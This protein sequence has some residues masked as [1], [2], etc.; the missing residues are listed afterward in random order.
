MSGQRLIQ[1]LEDNTKLRDGYAMVTTEECHFIQQWIKA[2]THTNKNTPTVTKGLVIWDKPI[3][4]EKPQEAT[5]T[6]LPK[7]NGYKQFFM[8]PL[9]NDMP[10]PL[11]EPRC[12]KATATTE[13]IPTDD[14]NITIRIETYEH[15]NTP[16]E[17]TKRLKQPASMLQATL[18]E[19]NLE[20]HTFGWRI[21]QQQRTTQLTG[22]IRIKPKYV[23]QI[24]QRSGEH[25]IIYTQVGAS[26]DSVQ[27]IPKETNETDITYCQRVTELAHKEKHGVAHRQGLGHAYLG[28]RGRTP[29]AK[30]TARYTAKGPPKHWGPS[31]LEAW[32]TAQ[33]FTNISAIGPPRSP[34]S[35]WHFTATAPTCTT[36]QPPDSHTPLTYQLHDDNGDHTF[37]IT[38]S[39]WQPAPRQPHPSASTPLARSKWITPIGANKR[40]ATTTTKPMDTSDGPG[41]RP[42]ESDDT[43]QQTLEKKQKTAATTSE[44]TTSNNNADLPVLTAG[45]LGE[46]IIDLGGAG[47]CGWRAAAAAMAFANGKNSTYINNRLTGMAIT[48][49][50]KA[51]TW[52]QANQKEWQ[53]FWAPD[54][55][56]ESGPVPTT[57][58]EWLEAILNKPSKWMDH[59]AT[60]GLAR[61]IGFDILVFEPKDTNT[62]ALT[63]RQPAHPGIH[64]Q[65]LVLLLQKD[66]FTTI[67]GKATEE[68]NHM[69]PPPG[70]CRFH[71]SGNEPDSPVSSSWCKP[72]PSLAPTSSSWCKPPVLLPRQQQQ[73]YCTSPRDTKPLDQPLTYLAAADNYTLQPPP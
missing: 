23:E 32:L 51:T 48:A 31:A 21:T 38:I 20:A 12:T 17:W 26:K 67:H 42:T 36:Q 25:G 11:P 16:A 1:L 58:N 64:S 65:P 29:T 34:R 24:T 66:H 54:P 9:C 13:P 7:N 6:W 15:L 19:L 40:P 70:P 61:A 56:T 35:P 53:P 45:P 69:T 59:Y 37:T 18:A 30:T 47:D 46:D 10:A 22:Y 72:P 43:T 33:R 8:A 14:D 28:I 52:L 3:T 5:T 49:R 4:A 57:A 41:K 27:W 73:H 62:W 63:A 2:Q 71:G 60:A 50:T 39:L 44:T 55:T 68:Y